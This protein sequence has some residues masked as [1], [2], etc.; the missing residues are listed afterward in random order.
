MSERRCVICGCIDVKYVK[1]DAKR[2]T[3]VHTR[4]GDHHYYKT[5]TAYYC[6]KCALSWCIDYSGIYVQCEY[7]GKEIEKE[8]V[9][10]DMDD[11]N[12]CSDE[13]ILAYHNMK[14]IGDSLDD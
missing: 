11:L 2:E 5:V 13:C 12:F 1:D 6:H 3:V 9:R 4:Y 14:P 8:R 7:C 10:V